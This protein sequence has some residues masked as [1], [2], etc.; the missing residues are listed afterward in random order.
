M[1][2]V[3]RRFVAFSVVLWRLFIN[4]N[5]FVNQKTVLSGREYFLP[6]VVAHS[7]QFVEIANIQVLPERRCRQSRLY[8]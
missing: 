1:V 4:N 6:F 3:S 5:Q 7:G 2:G 8:A